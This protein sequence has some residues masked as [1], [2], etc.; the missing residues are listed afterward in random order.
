MKNDE[1]TKIKNKLMS[2][3]WTEDLHYGLKKL[4]PEESKS[5]VESMSDSE[6]KQKVN[7][8][9]FQNDYIADYIEYIWN[10]SEKSFWKHVK[11]T[12]DM[13]AGVLWSDNMFYFEQLC[14][15]EIPNDVLFKVVDF[16]IKCENSNKYD[17]NLICCI[18][19]AQVND[20]KRIDEINNYI[21]ILDQKIQKSAKS[22]IIKM[23]NTDCHYY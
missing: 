1:L 19:K 8:R 22:K 6:I 16:A 9:R 23:A 21:S 11:C 15:I 12:F 7:N 5:I 14:S 2:S 17:Y 4:S 18:L 10:I 20:F 13:N 3:N